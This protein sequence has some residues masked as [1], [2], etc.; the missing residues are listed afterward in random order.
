MR[1][2]ISHSPQERK[3]KILADRLLPHLAEGYRINSRAMVPRIPTMS[4]KIARPRHDS[5][6]LSGGSV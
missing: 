6:S 1:L 2:F 5:A 3:I 4:P